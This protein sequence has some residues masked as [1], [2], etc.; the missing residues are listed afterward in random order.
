MRATATFP[1]AFRDAAA[2]ARVSHN[3]RK[4]ALPE[5]G[6]PFGWFAKPSNDPNQTV[7]TPAR[8]G[9]GK[10][11]EHGSG[12]ACGSQRG[13]RPDGGTKHKKQQRF[14][15]H[16]PLHSDAGCAQRHADADLACAPRHRVSQ[17]AVQSDA[18]YQQ[19]QQAESG[20]SLRDHA[21]K[22]ERGCGAA[23]DERSRERNNVSLSDGAR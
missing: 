3:A 15:Q 18:G 14:A 1:D 13:G 21:L 17:H 4:T 23:N 12:V 6:G 19:C 20:R 8:V 16:H 7:V 22:L 9:D 11:E 2:Q 10:A 5:T